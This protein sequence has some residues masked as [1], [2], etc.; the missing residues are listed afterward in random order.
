LPVYKDSFFCGLEREDGLQLVMMHDNGVVRCDVNIDSRFEG[1]TDVLHGGM[2]FGILD[3]IIWYAIFMETKK[4]CMTRHT[5][6]DFL[7]PVM[8]DTPYIAKGKFLKVEERDFLATAW[9]EDRHGE[10]CARV[11][12]IF[13]EAKDISAAHFINRFDFSRTS[14]KIKQHFYSL[15]DETHKKKVKS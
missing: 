2:I 11:D 12:A 7:K 14:P 9:M 1:Y 8:C 3:V 6:M 13:R 15:L 5:E 4:I 10:L